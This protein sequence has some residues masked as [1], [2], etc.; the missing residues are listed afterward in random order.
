MPKCEACTQTKLLLSMKTS[1]KHE[2]SPCEVGTLVVDP[3]AVFV[4]SKPPPCSLRPME[5][6]TKVFPSGE[7][8]PLLAG[9]CSFRE[10]LA[11]IFG[12]TEPYLLEPLTNQMRPVFK[13][14]YG[15]VWLGILL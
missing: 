8:V 9:D 2:S 1:G 4:I 12:S 15:L 14:K 5:N 3:L 10:L 13:S 11:P 7:T 6:P